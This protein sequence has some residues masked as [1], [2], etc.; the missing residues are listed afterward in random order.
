MKKLSKI[1][2]EVNEEEASKS[3]VGKKANESFKKF[4]K[5]VGTWGTVSEKAYYDIIVP[6]YPLK[7]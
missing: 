2:E 6:P 1:A 4:A 3:P 5:I 7:A